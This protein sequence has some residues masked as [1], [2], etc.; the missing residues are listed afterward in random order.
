M[1]SAKKLG[2]LLFLTMLLSITVVLPVL[3]QT[4]TPPLTRDALIQRIETQ[5]QNDVEL[6][7]TPLTP[8]DL[9]VLYEKDASA[10]GMTMADVKQVYDAAYKAA[11]P[12]ENPW[13][14]LLNPKGGWIFLLVGAL[15]VIVGNVLKGYLETGLKAV[16]EVA[17]Q[18]LARFRPFWAIALYRYRQSLENRYRT[19]E[20]PFRKGKPLEMRDVYVPLRAL[21]GDKQQ[22][23]A[24]QSI[25]QHKKLIVLGEPGSGKT[26]LLRHV[27]FTYASQGLDNI[28]GQPIPLYLELNR[29]GST[30]TA[31]MDALIQSIESHN[32]PRA[33]GFLKAALENGSLLILLDGL[34]EVNAP[35]RPALVKQIGDLSQKYKG[36]RIIVTCRKAVYHG[37]LDT[38]SEQR[39]EV[40]EFD[41]Q[42]IQRFMTSWQKDMPAGKSIEHFFR[43]LQERPQIMAL[44]RNPLLL[45]MIAYLYTDTEFALPHSRS[46]FYTRSTDLLL[47]QWKFERNQYKTVHKRLVLQR[48]ARY[49]QEKAGQAGERRTLDLGEV[50]REICDILPDLTLPAEVAQP[51]L[52]EIVQRS[53]L[54]LAM[55]GGQRYQFTHLTLQEYFAARALEADPGKLLQNFHAAPDAWREV[56]RL[57]CALEHDST[58]LLKE[59]YTSDPLI[60]LEC[61]SDAQRVDKDFAARIFDD[62]QRSLVEAATS[63]AL[64]S[65]LALLAANP[66]VRGLAWLAFIEQ[67]L[68]NPQTQPASCE[69]LCRT[70]LPEAATTLAALAE[71]NYAVHP[72]LTRMGNLAV[73][74][75][76]NFAK[77]GQ[78]WAMNLLVQ[79]G[80]PAAALALLPMIWNDEPTANQAA[81]RLAAL[82]DLPGVEDALNAAQLTSEQNK[83]KQLDWVWAPFENGKAPTLRAIAGRLAYLL[84]STQEHMVPVSSLVCSP[85]LALPIC[86]I[87]FSQKN[88][89]DRLGEITRNILAP[90]RDTSLEKT[91]EAYM[92]GRNQIFNSLAKTLPFLA[93]NELMK[94]TQDKERQPVLQDWHD[95]YRPSEYQFENSFQWKV[96]R[97]LFS[98]PF[99]TYIG[100][101]TI[102]VVSTVVVSLTTGTQLQLEILA[103]VFLIFAFLFILNRVVWQSKP[104]LFD[105]ALF[106]S[107]TSLGFVPAMGISLWA[108]QLES[109]KMYVWIIASSI[110]S[111][112]HGLSLDKIGIQAR[113][114]GNLITLFFIS[115]SKNSIGIITASSLVIISIISKN[116]L[117]MLVGIIVLLL[118]SILGRFRRSKSMINKEDL[119]F[120]IFEIVGSLVVVLL[121]G[122]LVF[123]I[124][125]LPA[126]L[127]KTTFNPEIALFLTLLYFASLI[128]GFWLARNKYLKSRNPMHA[129]LPYLP[130]A[131]QQPRQKRPWLFDF[132]Q[133]PFK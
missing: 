120:L 1:V 32:F 55:D 9:A 41:D 99:I 59:L 46:E 53:G 29:V 78:T 28:P 27:V 119:L 13:D 61:L 18:R 26:M 7:S 17:Y 43:T 40:I 71:N 128:V 3:A 30:D 117:A 52:D 62:F 121:S 23:D 131:P 56:V 51:L 34:D 125:Y 57:W 20:I 66:N 44:A 37:E 93:Q 91:F 42:Q 39:L 108:F 103:I 132:L 110:I 38:W 80:T 84:Y 24:Y 11:M 21:G 50:L 77:Q 35:S 76:G 106:I 95:L 126:H 14:E 75:L 114:P 86:A 109:T 98:I 54:V 69:V 100:L 79:I 65:A 124:L 104:A 83:A 49:N 70:N 101:F 58:P 6:G 12:V 22:L 96:L 72:Y 33:Q 111:I 73:P 2:I 5:A 123:S 31:L 129:F 19:L 60:A 89:S 8:S 15:L 81:W 90:F 67:G 47:D 116:S 115:I 68:Q 94:L 45:T 16:A 25:Q 10:V 130:N 102:F 48:L 112:L 87:A 127:F 107:F 122:I 118:N 63:D 64:A 88:M 105:V 133:S 4:A 74:G 85:R 113:L 92:K 36:I 97:V 82:L